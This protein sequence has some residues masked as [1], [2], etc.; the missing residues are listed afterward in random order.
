[1]DQQKLNQ[2]TDALRRVWEPS[3]AEGQVVSATAITLVDTAKR[4]VVN[5]WKNYM[6]KITEG[7][8]QGGFAVITSNTAT[9]LTLVAPGFATVPD[10]T[11]WYIILAYK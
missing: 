11:S 8:G 7:T 4:W 5:Q 6:V 3:A 2:D 9:Q 10:T 1:M